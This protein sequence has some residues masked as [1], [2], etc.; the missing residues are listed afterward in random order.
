M[1]TTLFRTAVPLIRRSLSAGVQEPRSQAFTTHV[2]LL[3][4]WMVGGWMA[5][6]AGLWHY[7]YS[8]VAGFYAVRHLAAHAF[9]YVRQPFEYPVLIGMWIWITAWVPGFGGYMLANL[10]GFWGVA[11]GILWFLRRLAPE[12]YQW[13]TVFPLL[14]V[15]GFQNWDVLAILPLVAAWWAFEANRPWTTGI[16][17]AVGTATKLFPIMAA[18]VMVYEWWVK[19]KRGESL[20]LITGM[21]L[22]WIAVNVPF[23]LSNFSGWSL[24]YRFNALRPAGADLWSVLHLTNSL[25]TWQ[26][27]AISFCLVVVAYLWAFSRIRTGASSR[28]IFVSVLVVF[29][30][31]NKVFSPQYILWVFAM[32]IVGEWPPWTLAVITAGGFLEFANSF[33]R[34]LVPIWRT[35]GETVLSHIV[36]GFYPFGVAIRYLILA[37]V[38]VVGTRH[39]VKRSGSVSGDL[40]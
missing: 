26:A 17:L 33:G 16:C 31:V 23:A 18:P 39:A 35:D 19:G 4:L 15:Y 21:T 6:L 14:L 10:I 5:V 29:F 30:V 37:W 22:V 20:S 3:T 36:K 1:E 11:V 9:P 27:N 7:Q 12:T 13:F 32:A 24:F 40:T 38:G 34:L 2:L 28:S 25:T 8:D